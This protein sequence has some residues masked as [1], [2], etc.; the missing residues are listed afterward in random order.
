M[1]QGTAPIVEGIGRM[2]IDLYRFSDKPFC[3]F[4]TP[5]LELYETEQI[6]RLEIARGSLENGTVEA[7]CLREV[8]RLML[9]HRAGKQRIGHDDASPPIKPPGASPRAG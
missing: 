8:A 4:E 7:G 2:R 1:L 5:L 3:I 6:K 9:G